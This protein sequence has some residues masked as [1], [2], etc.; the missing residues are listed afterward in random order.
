MN[1]EKFS[2]DQAL[3]KVE[4]LIAKLQR[5]EINIDDSFAQIEAALKTLKECKQRLTQTSQRMEK[6]FSDNA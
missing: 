4:L 1:E 3:Q 5:G 6:I 2:Y